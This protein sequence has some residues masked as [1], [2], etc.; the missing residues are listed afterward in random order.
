VALGL[1]CVAG[2]FLLPPWLRPTDGTLV[3]SA[4]VVGVLLAWPRVWPAMLLG[5][6]IGFVVSLDD[7][8]G[9]RFGNAV[10]AGMLGGLLEAWLD[11]GG[12][13]R[14]ALG[15]VMSATPR[16]GA[17][18]GRPRGRLPR[19]RPLVVGGGA[20]LWEGVVTTVRP[21]APSATTRAGLGDLLREGQ[22]LLA[23]VAATLYGASWL[24]AQWFYGAWGVTPEEVGL[25]TVDLLLAS[26]VT[27]VL[28]VAAIVAVD[29]LW[30][31]VRH[32]ALRVPVFTALGIGLGV[33]LGDV[34]SV[35]IYA[36]LGAAVG[37]GTAER[38]PLPRPRS[39]RWT[40][41][42]AGLAVAG[43]G[44]MAY[45]MADEMTLR[46]ER[47]EA[48]TPTLLNVQVAA[49]WAPTV[50]VWPLQGEELPAGLVSGGCA[51]RLGHAHGTTVL[52]RQGRVYRV[53]TQKILT[54]TA[55]CRR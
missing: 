24:A 41:I 17:E 26:G 18:H 38:V 3:P 48:A 31:R 52:L 43:L 46:L 44:V 33:W 28:I 51:H 39:A 42:V 32:P 35:L 55:G 30:R 1:A 34:A 37:V 2:T 5:A 53:P 20:L 50:R 54:A 47:G 6:G 40:R 25:T 7:P 49:L 15:R 14:A 4:F 16:T 8:T 23:I 36:T 10:I 11:V 45:G 29:L 9:D 22:I 13:V 21:A 12:Q 19:V 27:T